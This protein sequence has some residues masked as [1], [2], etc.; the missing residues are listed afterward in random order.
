LGALEKKSHQNLGSQSAPA[1]VYMSKLSRV[2]GYHSLRAKSHSACGNRTLHV[3]I[4][5]VRV[6]F[7]LVRVGITFVSVDL[8]LRVEITLVSVI[9]TRIRVKHTLL[10]VESTLCV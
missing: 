9:F 4:N 8:T 6:E 1:H 10:C 3:E 7:T 5:L 2:S